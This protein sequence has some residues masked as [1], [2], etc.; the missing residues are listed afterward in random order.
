MKKN[1]LIAI[2]GLLICCAYEAVGATTVSEPSLTGKKWYYTK[3]DYIEFNEDGTNTYMS[4]CTYV[5]DKKNDRILFYKDGSLYDY[6]NILELTESTLSIGKTSFRTYTTTPPKQLCERLEIPYLQ[7]VI[8]TGDQ[9]TISKA[10]KPADAD[11]QS[12]T[13]YDYDAEIVKVEGE[14]ITGV[15]PGVTIIRAK[16]NDGSNLNARCSVIVADETYQLGAITSPMIEP[17]DLGLPSATQWANMNIGADAPF[18]MSSGFE[19]PV[20]MASI[21]GSDWQYPTDNDFQELI[22]NCDVEMEKEYADYY[23]TLT[24]NRLYFPLYAAVF[25]SRVNGNKLHLY[26][27]T[28]TPGGYGMMYPYCL[29]DSGTFS[30]IEN[31]KECAL[32]PKISVYSENVEKVLIRLVRKTPADPTGIIGPQQ[33][34][35]N[36]HA[37][38]YYDLQGRRMTAEPRQGVYI[39][40][41]RK[42]VK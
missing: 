11:D 41:G 17:V 18:R 15:S 38:D 7:V 13:L 23:Q 33:E 19:A 28:I 29:I 26:A 16:T 25:T 10:I 22:D 39:Q 12:L 30:P 37:T 14:T 42:Y 24:G 20:D 3:R 32:D 31:I 6:T 21:V 5:L 35:G 8:K 34:A 40:N 1:V 27:Y 2:V 36:H 9:V 4:S